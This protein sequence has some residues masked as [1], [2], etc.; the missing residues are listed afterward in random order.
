M[1]SDKKNTQPLMNTPHP[2]SII[3][4][5]LDHDQNILS[6][7]EFKNSLFENKRTTQPNKTSNLELPQDQFIHLNVA[8]N[9]AKNLEDNHRI[10]K[11]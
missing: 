9:S 4:S 3:S 8:H 7:S 11:G 10:N 2:K 6:H 5:L 1:F